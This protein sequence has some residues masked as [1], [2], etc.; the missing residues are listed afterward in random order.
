MTRAFFLILSEIISLSC[1]FLVKL[2]VVSNQ[3]MS[4]RNPNVSE[5]IIITFAILII[6]IVISIVLAQRM[7]NRLIIGITTGITIIL[8]SLIWV[9]A[10]LTPARL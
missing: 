1:F 5:P 8:A 6:S 9:N 10:N 3:N 2:Y 7:S 4:F